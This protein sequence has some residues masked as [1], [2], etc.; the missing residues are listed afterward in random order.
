MGAS[1][2]GRLRGAVASRRR[3]EKVVGL[4]VV[5]LL[6]S[7][8]F[9]G[10]DRVRPE[11]PHTLAAH[12]AFRM[13]PFDVT[14]LGA[15]RAKDF[16]GADVTADQSLPT[17]P[18]T[19][20]RRLL[21]VEA[22]VKNP[23]KEPQYAATVTDAIA[24]GGAVAEEGF[25]KPTTEPTMV[26]RADGSNVGMLNPGLTHRV[27]LIVEVP[28]TAR[29]TQT[30]IRVSKELYVGKGGLT[31]NISEYY[32]LVLDDIAREGAIAIGRAPR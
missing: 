14:L 31:S 28:A 20:S 26:Y 22:D 25:G 10:L 1:P 23:G 3:S 30:T 6:I 5:G 8:P 11:P 9:G 12:Q 2:W 17:R 4:A 29:S 15:Y 24:I 27:A 21:I 16:I 19:P 7:A 13:G 32:W 18:S